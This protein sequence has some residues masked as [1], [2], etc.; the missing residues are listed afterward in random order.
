MEGTPTMGI[1]EI[2]A[3]FGARVDAAF[4]LEEPTVVTKS[5]KPR[6]VLVSYAFYEDALRLRAE[7]DAQ[8]T[9]GSAS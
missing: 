4:F 8:E 1:R 5:N 7:R 3:D 2:R 6:A 9:K